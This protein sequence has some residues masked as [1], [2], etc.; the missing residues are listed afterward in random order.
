MFVGKKNLFL[1]GKAT[2]L[3]LIN[4]ILPN[5]SFNITLEFRT[6][7]KKGL[8]LYVTNEEQSEFVAVQ[9]KDGRVV[10]SYD[11]RGQTR[12]IESQGSLYDG[13]WHRVSPWITVSIPN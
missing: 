5:F 7:Y 6:L 4:G 2:H 11:D 13:Q 8:L 1:Q 3:Q 9:L 12:E 10:T